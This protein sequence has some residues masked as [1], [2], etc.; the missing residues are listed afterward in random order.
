[1]EEKIV[2]TS[3]PEVWRIPEKSVP[4][5]N[6]VQ[7]FMYSGNISLQMHTAGSVQMLSLAAVCGVL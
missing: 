3:W 4:N 6:L 5:C 2:I 1:M 7:M